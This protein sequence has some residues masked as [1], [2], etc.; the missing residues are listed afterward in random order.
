MRY[1]NARL[2]TK[3]LISKGIFLGHPV[4]GICTEPT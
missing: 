4:F 2:T 3:E 1:D